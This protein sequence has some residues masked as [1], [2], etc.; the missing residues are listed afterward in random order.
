VIVELTW[1]SLNF[2]F[3]LRCRCLCL[4]AG[5]SKSACRVIVLSASASMAELLM[6]SLRVMD[7]G[8]V[9]VARNAVSSDVTSESVV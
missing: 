2:L 8:C 4:L 5:S 7:V 6:N 9:P 1:L 3:S